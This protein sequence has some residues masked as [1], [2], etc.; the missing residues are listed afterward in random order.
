MMKRLL[1]SGMGMLLVLVACSS[2]SQS[3]ADA[4]ASF[5]D[6]VCNKYKTCFPELFAAEYTSTTACAA[7]QKI[8]CT[9]AL[10][11]K[12]TAVTSGDATACGSAMSAAS[13]DK[14]SSFGRDP[15][16]EC[17]PKAG[18]LAAGTACQDNG[19]CASSYC[20]FG[21][22][23]A[24]GACG[25]RV[26]AG[27]KCDTSDDCEYTLVCGGNK[28]CV[29][30]GAAGDTCSSDKPCGGT[31]VCKT[32]TGGTTGT[33]T[34]PANAGEACTGGD[35]NLT[36][37]LFCNPQSAV[38]QLIKFEAPGAACGLTGGSVTFCQGSGASCEA[39]AGATTGTC[40]AGIAD[41]AACSATGQGA[42]CQSP[43]RCVNSVCTLPTSCGG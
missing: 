38:C 23:S 18:P 29:K 36:K 13:C 11:A 8:S 41:G 19:Q 3:T 4:C 27:S 28:T 1:G 7:R 20:K 26:A 21:T 34:A 12:S 33:C 10:N 37:G 42:S 22:S 39:A 40:K 9:N 2:T 16:P 17:K 43:A 15:L 32:S 6:S 25:T 31:L 24:C 14:F 35:C 30:P 5:S